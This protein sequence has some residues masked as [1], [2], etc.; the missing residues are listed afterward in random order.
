MFLVTP[1]AC[2]TRFTSDNVALNY[3]FKI[4]AYEQCKKYIGHVN[5]AHSRVE[6]I[7]FAN[8]QACETVFR[9]IPA[10]FDAAMK[11]NETR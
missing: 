11:E 1:I 9:Q 2:A 10:K 7:A 8:R 5:I 4:G 6:P 3:L